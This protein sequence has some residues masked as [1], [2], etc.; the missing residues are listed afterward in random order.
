MQVRYE[1]VNTA[2]LKKLI[3]LQIKIFPESSYKQGFELFFEK[4][5]QALGH[6]MDVF[7]IVYADDMPVGVTGLYI[8]FDVEEHKSIWLNWYGIL[9]T[10]RGKGLGKR[11]LLDSIEIA[12]NY[13]KQPYEVK[14][15]RLYTNKFLNP[16]AQPLYNSAMD[17]KEHYTNDEIHSEK[18]LEA[19]QYYFPGKK[20]EEY[21]KQIDEAFLIFSKG[22]DTNTI[23]VPWENRF[24]NLL[25]ALACEEDCR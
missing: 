15:F 9:P 6:L 7:Y 20:Q 24:L 8:P 16:T 23:M 11:I 2:N 21:K 5:P 3:D 17:L 22:L 19:A 14:Y 4:G 18:F 13:T 10:C 12:K 25:G 1:E